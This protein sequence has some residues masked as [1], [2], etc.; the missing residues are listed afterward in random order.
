MVSSVC[1][2]WTDDTMATRGK[3]K[4][5]EVPEAQEVLANDEGESYRVTVALGIT[6]VIAKVRIITPS[7]SDSGH[8]VTLATRGDGAVVWVDQACERATS[9]AF[10]AATK[11]FVDEAVTAWHNGDPTD[12][13]DYAAQLERA[14]EVVRVAQRV[15]RDHDSKATRM[16]LRAAENARTQVIYLTIDRADM[17]MS[18]IASL[19]G[20]SLSKL[21]RLKEIR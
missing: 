16:T 9:P 13:Y 11:P 19:A 5:E 14:R 4:G 10:A 12:V 2:V 17:T 3:A 8:D 1:L 20:I 7:Q 15:R 18:E 21:Y 6:S